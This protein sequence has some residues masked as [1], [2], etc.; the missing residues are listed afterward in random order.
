MSERTMV[1]IIR[2]YKNDPLQK[3]IINQYNKLNEIQEK[4][5]DLSEL[6]KNMIKPKC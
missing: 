4:L 2:D 1:D 5:P 6:F 3:T